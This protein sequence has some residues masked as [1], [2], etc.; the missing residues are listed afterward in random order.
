MIRWRKR[1]RRYPW[2]ST[3]L[4]NRR[5]LFSKFPFFFHIYVTLI[6][7]DMRTNYTNFKHEIKASLHDKLNQ[8]RQ[9]F[10][11]IIIIIMVNIIIMITSYMIRDEETCRGRA[12]WAYIQSQRWPWSRSRA[13][14]TSGFCQQMN[15]T[16]MIMTMMMMN[17]SLSSLTGSSKARATLLNNITNMM[18]PSKNGR[19]TNQ[20]RW[21]RTL[22]KLGQCILRKFC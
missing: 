2:R 18:K 17:L 20:W 9:I 4:W 3:H 22:K 10:I 8:N 14:P 11:I 19:V 16:M 5:K 21:I 1:R 7:F 12:F 6:L 13:G 15:M